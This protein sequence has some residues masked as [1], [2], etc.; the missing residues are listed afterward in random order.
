MSAIDR[1]RDRLEAG[2]PPC[3]Y[4]EH[5]GFTFH[6]EEME[7]GRTVLS[8]DADERFHNP[9]GRAHGGLL[10]GLADSAMGSVMFTVLGDG[11]TCTNVDLSIKFLRPT[12]TGALRAEGSVLKAGRTVCVAEAR[13]LD[14]E[15]R[16]VARAESTFLR[17][18]A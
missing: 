10:C 1:V 12:V 9:N 16:L 11:E 18:P 8:V 15:G 14:A 7:R 6:V 13:I 17:M 2:R 3:L 4:D 5:M